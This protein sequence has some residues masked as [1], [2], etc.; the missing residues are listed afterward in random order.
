MEDVWKDIWSAGKVLT[1][2]FLTFDETVKGKDCLEL[3][4]GCSCLA[5]IAAVKL[6]AA[7]VLVTDKISDATEE[8][9]KYQK[10]NLQANL[11]IEELKKVEIK[12]LDWK[13]RKTTVELLKNIKNLDLIYGSD[14]FYDPEVFVP[15]IDTVRAIL[16][17]FPNAQFIF[18]Y[19]L[20]N[21][22]WFLDLEFEWYYLH[23][24]LLY[25]CFEDNHEIFVYKVRKM[26]EN[27]KAEIRPTHMSLKPKR[28]FAGVEGG[29]TNF[30]FVFIDDSGKKLAEG[31]GTEL[32]LLL[33]GIEKAA[34]KIATALF[35]AAKKAN[36]PLP[37]ESIGLGLA[38]AEDDEVNNE[39][40]EYFIKTYGDLC[41]EIHLT[42]DAVI[43]I[44][45]TFDKG[46]VVIIAGTGSSCRLLKE[47]GD[48]FGCGGWG[49]LIG[50]G[51]SGSWIALKAIRIIFDVDDGLVRETDS[52]EH[53]RHVILKHF[54]I[55]DKSGLLDILYGNKFH[56]AHVASLCHSL[57]NEAV[58]D[59][60]IEKLF[61]DAGHILGRHLVA[62][63][64]NFDQG[65]FD[66][67]P[68][69]AIGSVW[70]SW[71]L[72]KGGLRD[73]LA[74]ERRIKTVSFFELRESPAVGAAILAAQVRLGINFEETTIRKDKSVLMHQIKL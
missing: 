25:K 69:L 28:A 32:N 71:N 39:M 50:D 18:A 10:E 68:V 48:V 47:D 1:N 59:P 30:N 40:I 51:G 12:C 22:W 36:I 73:A 33:E 26:T 70:K 31:S 13:K 23:R 58:G 72:L 46:G 67:V 57:A 62:V 8:I 6:G 24:E 37:L 43:S 21:E 45:A 14:I 54:K 34:E 66:D 49:H 55:K 9:Q 3:G 41:S 65:M 38:G 60:I 11:T 53:L 64:K 44:A 5:S 15:I 63:S 27:E 20:R 29:A 16:N 19:E 42:T 35:D 74:A 2:Y 61:Y 17:R 7:S 52:I 56:K 4:A